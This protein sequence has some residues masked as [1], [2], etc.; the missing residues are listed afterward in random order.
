MMVARSS[1]FAAARRASTSA[2]L[3]GVARARKSA[4]DEERGPERRVAGSNATSAGAPDS[5]ADDLVVLLLPADED[6][7]RAGVEEDLLRLPAG[8][9]RV[10]GHADGAGHQHAEVGDGP[11]GAVGREDRHP[12]SGLDAGADQGARHGLDARCEL[13]VGDGAPPLGVAVAHR[14][15]RAETRRRFPDHA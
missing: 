11:V 9:R 14:L 1:S 12:V 5:K 13:G 8:V 10:D 15:P 6:E 3:S 4:S 7:L 2:A